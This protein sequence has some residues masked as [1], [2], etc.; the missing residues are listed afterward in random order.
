VSSLSDLPPDA[1][2]TDPASQPFINSLHAQLDR[3]LQQYT[4]PGQTL[5]LALSGGLD[6]SVLFD[7]MLALSPRHGLTL[8]A[9]HVH[10][11]LSAN[12]NDWAIFCQQLCSMANVPLEIRRINVPESAEG[13]EAAARSLR[14]QVL[15]ET[16]ADHIVLAHHQ[17]DQAETLLLQLLRGA[18]VK[19]LSAMAIC[20]A[21][22]RLLRPLLSVS[23]EMLHA[24][25]QARQ[26]K[27]VEDESNTML[28]FDRNFIR[29]QVFPVLQQRY[30]A[31]SSVLARTAGHMAETAGLLDDLAVQDLQALGVSLT[32]ATLALPLKCLQQPSVARAKNVLRWWLATQRQPMP[33]TA[34]LEEML[35][36]ALH[37]RQDA[38]LKIAVA[39]HVYLHRYQDALYIQNEMKFAH[40]APNIIWQG[41]SELSLPDGSVLRFEPALGSGLGYSRLEMTQLRVTYRQGGERFK[42]HA[43][44]PTRL[45]KQLLRETGI[46]PWLRD[47]QPLI[48][49]NKK[50][51]AV[52][53]IGVAAGLQARDGEAGLDI[54]WHLSSGLDG[55]AFV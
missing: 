41:E 4:R 40:M 36:Q 6:S 23:R 1:K 13:I 52:P 35:R 19:G 30:P 27:W 15:L 28:C 10:H 32:D 25:A 38:K 29:R 8:R 14:Y 54:S 9:M 48:Y 22:R 34:R 12:A 46:P 2:R 26:L 43:D 21:K 37:A 17:D 20:D 50:L 11:G 33:S 51:V 47:R 31:V 49:W 16:K 42:P 53:G 55:G 5:L 7:L 3:F 18:G 24:Y 44:R 45:L 39:P